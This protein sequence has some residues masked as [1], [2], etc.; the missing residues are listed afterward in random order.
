MTR[1]VLQEVARGPP[2]GLSLEMS[3]GLEMALEQEIDLEPK[4]CEG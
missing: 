2:M 1:A 3:P 4:T